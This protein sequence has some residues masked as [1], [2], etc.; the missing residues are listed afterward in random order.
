MVREKSTLRFIDFCIFTLFSVSPCG[1]FYLIVLI[2]VGTQQFLHRI[3]DS[4]FCR[5]VQ[6]SVAVGGCGDGRVTEPHLHFFQACV[7]GDEHGCAGMAQVVEAD[8]F[9]AEPFKQYRKTL[10][11]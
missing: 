10:A 1:L 4:Y 9:H 7:V 11:G 6:M 3:S 2:L 8:L 5:L